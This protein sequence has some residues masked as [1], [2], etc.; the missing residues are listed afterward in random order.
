MADIFDAISV[1]RPKRDIFDKI[2]PVDQIE[3][4]RPLQR[5]PDPFLEREGLAIR[6][7]KQF[8]N[9]LPETAKETLY[10]LGGGKIAS[11]VTA[12]LLRR[13]LK[14]MGIKAPSLR[15]TQK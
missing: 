4:V 2:R 9:I 3:P 12:G 7:L 5:Q 1:E 6:G 11:F 8:A 14:K 13:R 15:E 10:G